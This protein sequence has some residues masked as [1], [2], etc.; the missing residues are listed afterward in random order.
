MPNT[1]TVTSELSFKPSQPD[2]NLAPSQGPPKQGDVFSY[3]MQG[4]DDP[5]PITPSQQPSPAVLAW[6]SEGQRS[7]DAADQM[8]GVFTGKYRCEFGCGFSGSFDRV[9]RHENTCALALAD[10]ATFGGNG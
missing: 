2:E 3:R 4:K 5:R 7:K 8:G 1:G 6:S 9:A 10:A